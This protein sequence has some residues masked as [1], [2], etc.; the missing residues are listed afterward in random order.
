MGESS[1]GLINTQ[2][3]KM[4][5]SDRSRFTKHILAKLSEDGVDVKYNYKSL[6]SKTE[7]VENKKESKDEA[8]RSNIDEQC[9]KLLR[10]FWKKISQDPPKIP[11]LQH[12]AVPESNLQEF[13]NIVNACMFMRGYAA[14][15]LERECAIMFEI[16]WLRDVANMEIKSAGIRNEETVIVFGCDIYCIDSFSN[17]LVQSGFEEVRVEI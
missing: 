17:H 15:V 5:D 9:H 2:N 13:K 16:E 12:L 7:V 8:M 11:Q 1:P 10:E 14:K 3:T 4:S 6:Y